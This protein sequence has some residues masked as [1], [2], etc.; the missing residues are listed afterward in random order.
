[1]KQKAESSTKEVAEAE[2]R[3][4]ADAEA[5]RKTEAEAVSA[6]SEKKAAEAVEIALRLSPPDRQRVQVALTALGFDTR[7]N[8]GA[9]G[10]RSREM[11]TNWQKARNQPA[12]GFLN[13][14][15]NQALLKEAAP[16]V[17]KFDDDQKKIEDDKK[18]VEEEKKKADEEAKARTAAAAVPAATTVAPPAAQGAGAA[19]GSYRGAANLG[20]GGTS[21]AIPMT[22]QVANGSGAG[23]L[24]SANCGQ[25]P[26]SIRISPTGD[27]SGE[28][29]G[30]DRSCGKVLLGIRGRL[31]G[32]QLQL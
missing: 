8:D 14:V 6:A 18:K 19:D 3:Q 13:G 15:Q 23:A 31:A 26:I 10:P 27:V 20:A 29:T 11:I 7:G 28:A 1:A 24:R 17:A 22:V 16:A 12:T 30:F 5:R 32:N 4:K 2:A 25:G 9:F 21:A